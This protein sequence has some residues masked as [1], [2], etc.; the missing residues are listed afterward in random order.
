MLCAKFLR[1]GKDIKA[2]GAYLFNG[3]VVKW[4]LEEE[5]HTMKR[6]LWQ[7]RG[8]LKIIVAKALSKRYESRAVSEPEIAASLEAVK[9]L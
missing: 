3:Q 7:S 1:L 6:G 2:E 5:K 4:P 8:G 9:F